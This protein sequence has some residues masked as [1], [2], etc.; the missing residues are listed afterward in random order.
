MSNGNK[1]YC[2][3]VERGATICEQQCNQCAKRFDA[4]EKPADNV[5]A[6]KQ[7]EQPAPPAVIG[8]ITITLHEDGNFQ[9]DAPW[10]DR[11]LVKGMIGM[12]L[13]VERDIAVN[14][15][16]QRMAAQVKEPYWRRKARELKAR[17]NAGFAAV[18]KSIQEEAERKKS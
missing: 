7:P 11:I 2:S 3:R 10:D 17:M 5:V 18:G 1:F 4:T 16:A 8:M 9:C 12:F 14:R 15:K 13:D 6:L